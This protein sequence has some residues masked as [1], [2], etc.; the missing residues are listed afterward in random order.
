[1]SDTYFRN[2]FAAH[3]GISPQAYVINKRLTQAKTIIENGDYDNLYDVAL[4]V[5]YE[6]ALYFSRVFKRKYGVAP[7]R[8]EWNNTNQNF[9]SPNTLR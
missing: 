8:V 4:A 2:I 5:G 3:F 6:D 1:M 7:S 9:Y